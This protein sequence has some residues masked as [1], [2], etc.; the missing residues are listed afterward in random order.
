MKWETVTPISVGGYNGY[1]C[2]VWTSTPLGPG[3][4]DHAA[5]RERVRKL[6]ALGQGPG[7]RAVLLAQDI[8]DT[9]PTVVRVEVTNAVGEGVVLSRS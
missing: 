7:N 5:L 8:L 6:H 1:S 9:E 3:P 4:F 2:R